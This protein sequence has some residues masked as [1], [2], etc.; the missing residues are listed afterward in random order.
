MSCGLLLGL[1]WSR[2][3]PSRLVRPQGDEQGKMRVKVHQV[4]RKSQAVFAGVVSNKT[5]VICR[6]RSSR[7]FW[8]VQVRLLL[9]GSMLHVREHDATMQ[10]WWLA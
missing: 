2:L 7:I 1:V 6:S 4:K 10:V 9:K 5:H 3:V 8:L